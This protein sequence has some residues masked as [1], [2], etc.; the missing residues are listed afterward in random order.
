M[1]ENQTILLVDDE[2]AITDNLAPF[3]ERSGFAVRVAGDGEQALR[4]V[5][6]LKPD[7]LV[8]DVLMPGKNGFEERISIL[9]TLARANSILHRLQ[10]QYMM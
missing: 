6:E 8:L 4:L 3:L 7:V 1:A 5:D 10:L 9:K 2:S